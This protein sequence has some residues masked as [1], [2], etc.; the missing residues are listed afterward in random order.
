MRRLLLACAAALVVVAPAAA[1]GA[2]PSAYQGFTSQG[3]EITFERGPRGVFR[4]TIAVRA[5]CQ[6]AS[7]QNKGAY[8]FTLRATDAKA[9][10]VKRGAFVVVL[11]G[12]GNV[13]DATVRGSFNKRGTGRGTLAATGRGK[14]PGGEDL[15]TCRSPLVHW[16]A[17]P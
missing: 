1:L 2:K 15:G 3:H 8:D 17:A 5:N 11:P 7:G 9:D 6:T 12:N 13:P 16:T 10:P 14:G 4:M